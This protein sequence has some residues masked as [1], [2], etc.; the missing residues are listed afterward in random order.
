M[1]SAQ[2]AQS[3]TSKTIAFHVSHSQMVDGRDLISPLNWFNQ[4]QTKR[5]NDMNGNVSRYNGGNVI[6]LRDS[7]DK[8]KFTQA[9]A[10]EARNDFAALVRTCNNAGMSQRAI[11]QLTGVHLLTISKM[12]REV[13]G[14]AGSTTTT[15]NHLTDT[16]DSDKI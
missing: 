10:N 12:V 11:G 14:D 4:S 2:L 3:L 7:V 15:I 13:T 8:W 6:A 1:V 16:S 9:L 5:E